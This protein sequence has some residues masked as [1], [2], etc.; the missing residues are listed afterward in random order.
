MNYPDFTP[1]PND[2]LR[3]LS[4][5]NSPHAPEARRELMK[6][7]YGLPDAAPNEPGEDAAAGS[8]SA[9]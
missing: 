2:A 6:R 1:L 7:A 4:H 9:P 3:D 5:S 8:P